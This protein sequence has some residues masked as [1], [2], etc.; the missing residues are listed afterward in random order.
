M[1]KVT[2]KLS[3]THT[4]IVLLVVATIAV[5]FLLFLLYL[6][7]K[8]NETLRNVAKIDQTIHAHFSTNHLLFTSTTDI[9]HAVPPSL[10][11]KITDSMATKK[12]DYYTLISKDG[13]WIEMYYWNT[14]ENNWQRKQ[15]DILTN[16]STL[17]TEVYNTKCSKT[18]LSDC[19]GSI[20]M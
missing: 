4:E 17:T 19:P 6:A 12:G 7:H 8:N 18:R 15:W 2:R 5:L 13:T 9:R 3:I 10:A 14:K 16:K 20:F 1:K 11:K